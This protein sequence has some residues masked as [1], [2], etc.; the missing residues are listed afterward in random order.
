MHDYDM[1]VIGSGPSGRRAAIQSA[2]L[3]KRVLVVEKGRSV[4]PV[5][6]VQPVDG[7]KIWM[8]D[9]AA[10]ERANCRLCAKP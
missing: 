10:A 3:G 7:N 8:L 2:K 5:Q 4:Y 9:Q 1:I 6:R